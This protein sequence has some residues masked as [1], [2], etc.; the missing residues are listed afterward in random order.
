[1]VEKKSEKQNQ[2]VYSE[3]AIRNN[4]AVLEYARTCQAA[5]CGIASGA[6]GLTSIWGFVF[7]FVFVLV[8]AAFWEYKAGFQW[9]NFF[10]SR[11]LSVTHSAVG[12]LFTY[13]LFW[14]FF[15]GM[16]YM[17]KE[18]TKQLEEQQKQ[19]QNYEKKLKDVVR[20]Y[21]SLE[22]EK[23][24]LEVALE[25][26]GAKNDNS[27]P[28]SEEP[29]EEKS[30]TT[31]VE[32]IE[33][34]KQAIATLT[35]ENKKKEIAFQADRKALLQK[36]EDLQGQLEKLKNVSDSL[37][38][39]KKLKEKLKQGENEKE[40]M[41]ADHGA[42][43]AEMQAR[44]A[45]ERQHSEQMEK[46]IAELYKK[47]Q[48][49]EENLKIIQKLEKE[50]RDWKQKAEG[51]PTVRIL[52]EELE[53]AKKQ[54]S[55]DLAALKERYSRT[56]TLQE[57]KDARIASL[58]LRVQELTQENV[59]TIKEKADLMS[60]IDELER[61]FEFLSAESENLK[62]AQ[63]RLSMEVDDDTSLEQKLAET[64]SEILK[65]NP[66]FNV[67]ECLKL[68][69]SSVTPEPLSEGVL[70]EPESIG[71]C[72]SCESAQKDLSY[73]RNLIGHLQKKLKTLESSQDFMKKDHEQITTNLRSRIADLEAAQEK[74]Y[75]KLTA[76][77]K[78]KVAELEDEMAKQRQ[79]MME[80]IAEKDR[81]IEMTKNSLAALCAQQPDPV[82]PPQSKSPI[83][84]RNSNIRKS[85]E[86]IRS[87]LTYH[88][89]ENDSQPGPIARLGSHEGPRSI[90]YE[91]ELLR[92]EQE[93]SELR[94]I[95]RLSETK[96]REIEQA[97][98]T[99]DIQYLQIVE[100]L[101]EEI[102][103][104]EGRL[105]LQKSEVNLEYLRNV[106][107]QLLSSSSAVSRKHI[108][109]AMGAVLKLTPSEMR[110][111]DS[112]NPISRDSSPWKT[113]P[114]PIRTIT[115]TLIVA[116]N[117]FVLQFTNYISKK[118][119]KN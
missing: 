26:V 106:F 113:E 98:L 95:I 58:E 65:I 35:I 28:S 93:I 32:K 19:L 44:Y 84:R 108:L 118:A 22:S 66:S 114:G 56:S 104:L 10:T 101:K 7:Y 82:D 61:K 23:K 62:K 46:Q 64:Y 17:S 119:V 43:L 50:V 77:T 4:F 80:I 99:K 76:E 25:A 47:I 15:Y 33:S 8:Q 72:N 13:I 45:K 81:E 90:F 69:R 30:E 24:A 110:K 20:A 52:R 11:W 36:N 16:V 63:R 39:Q 14:V 97:S 89:E 5:T 86:S 59:Q 91:Q 34:L 73:F 74:T 42:V 38:S 78:R 109:K 88:S 75:A 51:T 94:H 116:A 40:K 67:Y 83:S 55:Q 87:A 12:G 96:I 105:T 48:A 53:N 60:A 68:S 6:L 92:K 49:G 9:Q 107:V 1:M 112:W 3:S 18:L 100:T 102:R 79:R 21:K 111:V 2:I 37:N 41:L 29:L 71:H 70:S 103:V 57:D 54:H 115:F 85:S 117:C 31:E 27:A